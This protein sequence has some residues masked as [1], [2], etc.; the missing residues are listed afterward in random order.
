MLKNEKIEVYISY[1]NYTHYIK[2]GYD[3]KINQNLEILTIHLPSS[4]HVPYYRPQ[5]I[6]LFWICQ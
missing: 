6:D 3:A 1:R 4:S 2:L 5:K